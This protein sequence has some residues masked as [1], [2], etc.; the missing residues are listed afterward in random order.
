MGNVM[1]YNFKKVNM[2]I[3]GIFA[4]GFADGTV[5]TSAPT[6]ERRTMTA[7]A[8]GTVTVQQGNDPT[9]T[10]TVVFAQNSGM[11][12]ELER[13]YYADEPFSVAIMDNNQGGRKENY[14][15]CFVQQLPEAGHGSEMNNRE[16]TILVADYDKVA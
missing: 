10:I 4:Y 9:G 5:I 12:A 6:V 2:I 14:V 15:E 11:N 16:W 13:L 3:A 8:D 1:R 7:G